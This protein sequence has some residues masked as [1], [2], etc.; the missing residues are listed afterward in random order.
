MNNIQF[1]DFGTQNN[2]INGRYLSSNSSN[3][4]AV[5]SPYYDKEIATVPDSNF[6]DL[7]DA[8]Q[9]AKKA[10]PDWAS[11]NIRDRAEVMFNLKSIMQKNLEE[12]AYLIA[13][14]NGKTVADAKGSILRGKEVVEFATSL[15]SVLRGD[16]SPV[17]AGVTCT[18]THEPL[19]VVAGITPFNFPAMVPLWMIPLAITTGNCFILKP[20]EQTP[21]SALKIAEY[22]KEA[23]LPDGVFSVING[24]RVAVEGICDHPDIKAVA[25]VGSSNVAKIVYSR[26]TA[27]GKRALC[28]GGA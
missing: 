7:D 5:I 10:F 19:G 18:M 21:L 26:S 12:L 14:D 8:V 4:I 9:G 27:L 2:W 6:S 25:F 16:S 11:K 24:S 1:Q 23:G 17:G 3:T 28:M 22:L 20:S 15:P 13:L